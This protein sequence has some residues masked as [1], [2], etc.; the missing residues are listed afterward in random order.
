M[1]QNVEIK[2]GRKSYFLSAET[3]YDRKKLEKA[4]KLVDSLAQQFLKANPAMSNDEMLMFAAISMAHEFDDLKQQKQSDEKMLE[5]LHN[6]LA[7]K[8]EKLI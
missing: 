1:T 4:A 3:D 6:S 5:K 7:E 8:L 2:I